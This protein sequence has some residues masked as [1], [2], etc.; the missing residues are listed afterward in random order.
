MKDVY[1]QSKVDWRT[2]EWLVWWRE[3]MRP[4]LEAFSVYVSVCSCV[5]VYAN[6]GQKPMLDVFLSHFPH[7]VLRLVLN[8]TWSPP[9]DWE[10]GL[11]SS[12]KQAFY[13]LN[14]HPSSHVLQYLEGWF[15]PMR[16]K[17]SVHNN[18]G[19]HMASTT[20]TMSGQCRKVKLWVNPC[21]CRW[22]Q[23]SKACGG[24]N[25][26]RVKLSFTCTIYICFFLFCFCFAFLRQGLPV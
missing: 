7:S 6:G 18:F 4:Y 22:P 13:Q 16:G 10:L 8:W 14:H 19:H 23:L 2:L 25:L 5:C 26:R 3:P 12:F 15:T 9:A 11:T 24:A 1:S 20:E 17:L 21:I